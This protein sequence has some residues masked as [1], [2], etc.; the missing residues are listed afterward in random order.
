MGKM[1]IYTVHQIS[2]NEKKISTEPGFEPGAA[3]R[4]ARMLPLCDARPSMIK[5]KRKPVILKILFI[6][7]FY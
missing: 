7:T 6:D 1:S 4:E 2:I 5:T 3:G